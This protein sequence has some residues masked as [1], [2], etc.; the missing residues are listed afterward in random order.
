MKYAAVAANCSLWRN[1][2]GV[3]VHAIESLLM[4]TAKQTADD[5]SVLI[6]EQERKGTLNSPAPDTPP[7]LG[8]YEG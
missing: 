2:I 4:L 6:R 5:R 8:G 1:T 3:L 7:H